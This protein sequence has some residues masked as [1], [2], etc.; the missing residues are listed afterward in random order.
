MAAASAASTTSRWQ[1]SSGR[2]A[3]YINITLLHGFRLT[4]ATASGCVAEIA[5]A[6][7]IV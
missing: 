1:I 6:F 4:I 3:T 7:P 5:C 2:S